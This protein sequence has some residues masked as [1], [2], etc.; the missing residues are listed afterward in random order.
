VAYSGYVDGEAPDAD[1]A[2][3]AQRLRQLRTSLDLSQEQL[4]HRLGVSFA[5]VNRWE[6]GRTRMSA[7]AQRAL[8]EFEARSIPL[9]PVPVP[10][11]HSS[12]VGRESELADLS[13]LLHG[14]SPLI[15]I[16]GPGGVGK[17]RLALEAIR[18]FADPD[19]T[20]II[21]L[22]PVRHP[23][24]L[25]ST[26]ASCLRL[27][28]QPGVEVLSSVEA[29][30]A[31]TP[32]LVV[33]DGAEHLR[34]DVAALV[35]LLLTGVRGVRIMVTSRTVLGVPGELC[36]PVPPM[37]CPSSAAPVT[38][39]ASSDAVRLFMA[40]AEERLPGFAAG[41]VAPRVIAELCRRL[42]CLPLAIELIAGWVGTLSLREIV[43]Q[44]AALLAAEPGD[45]TDRSDGT[46]VDVVRR[47]YDLLSPEQRRL[48]P[49]LSVFAG[50]FTMADAAAVSGSGGP[51]LAHAVR[52]LVDSSWLLVNRGEPNRFSMLATM[53]VFA[54]A[55]LD[56]RDEGPAIRRRHAEHLAALAA[57]S[58]QGLAGPG[59]VSWAA[60]LAA[61]DTDLDV[62]LEWAAG[63]D[64]DL[65]LRMGAAL[66]RWWLTSGRL[67]AGRGWLGRFLAHTTRRDENS[68]RAF[69]SAAVLAAEN[70]DYSEAVR[71][72][73]T[74]LG[75]FDALGLRERSAFAATVLGSAHRYLG[76][77]DAAARCFHTAMDL[78]AEVGDRR[79]M[80]VAMNNLALMALDEG[81]LAK[82]RDNLKRSLVIKRQLG[83]QNSLAIG[84]ANLS[85]VLIRSGELDAARRALDEAAELAGGLGNPQVTGLL[86]ANRGFLAAEQGRWAESADHYRAATLAHE[87]ADQAHDIVVAL[88]G[89]GRAVHRLGRPDEAARHLRA[90]EALAAGIANPQRLADVRA[91]LAEIGESADADALPD[92]LTVRQA[93]VLGLV[94]S[95]LSNKQIAAELC[96]SQGTV[97][98][99]LATVY[100]K[101]GLGGRVEA[102]RYAVT[103]GLAAPA[104]QG[105]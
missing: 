9:S 16:T 32:R 57:D 88:T 87:E 49:A 54:T 33:F 89:L 84:L 95:G 22:E 83:D 77:R 6:A 63:S 26:V 12:F 96:L 92:G 74:A 5:T 105:G 70:G 90:A 97:E 78:R 60:R 31:V 101:L 13:M 20:V 71:L 11:P 98:R 25:T 19:E 45:G 79:G 40:R 80:S 104:R 99:H 35:S 91:A 7:R 73:R 24:S 100:R 14:R 37:A 2:S 69:C 55:R 34:D 82:A 1:V 36:W 81:D 23:L 10:V 46:L 17:T 47:S 67:A 38:D 43:E 42:D 28:D 51:T 53:R 50:P 56:E 59:S 15:S 8:A 72:A 44:G 103:H 27:R 64:P 75:I 30:L 94:A 52:G 4:A 76:D 93:D 102:A 21:P 66:W 48:L 39:I 3:A 61:A 29:A 65:G 58:E 41:N 62:A 85:D 68:G 86:E 18:R